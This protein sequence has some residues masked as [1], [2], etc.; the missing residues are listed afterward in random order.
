[1][2]ERLRGGESFPAFFTVTCGWGES[3]DHSGRVY[4]FVGKMMC[5]S[6]LSTEVHVALT[7]VELRY[8]WSGAAYCTAMARPCHFAGKKPR[9]I[10]ALEYRPSKVHGA[11]VMDSR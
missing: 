7:A 3:N 8:R 6:T 10:I 5:E 11:I 2:I 9:T 1:M 4:D